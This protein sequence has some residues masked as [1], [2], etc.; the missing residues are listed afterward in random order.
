MLLSYIIPHLLQLSDQKVFEPS[1]FQLEIIA[2]FEDFIRDGL[3]F[4]LEL[5]D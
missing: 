3:H 5:L 1:V 2:V 4:D